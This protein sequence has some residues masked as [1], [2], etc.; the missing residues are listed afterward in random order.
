MEI[1]VNELPPAAQ[2]QHI[3]TRSGFKAVM[4]LVGKG[5]IPSLN[6]SAF[7]N[8]FSV[9]EKDATE[10]EREIREGSLGAN[11]IAKLLTTRY[12]KEK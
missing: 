4:G 2:L 12:A 5:K 6:I 10:I 7:T 9:E 11:E 8:T 1:D 3:L